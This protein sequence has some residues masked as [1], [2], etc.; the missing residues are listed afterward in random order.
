MSKVDLPGFWICTS[1]TCD[2]GNNAPPRLNLRQETNVQQLGERKSQGKRGMNYI[3]G[4]CPS[5]FRMASFKS[6]QS[7]SNPRAVHLISSSQRSLC[8]NQPQCLTLGQ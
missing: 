7:K 6:V 1:M 4:R 8:C 5:G 2:E 3:T